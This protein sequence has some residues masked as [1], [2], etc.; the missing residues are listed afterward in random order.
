[1]AMELISFKLD[2][3]LARGRMEYKLDIISLLEPKCSHRVEAVGFSRW[4][5]LAGRNILTLSRPNR[6]TRKHLW[7]DLSLT[8]P[9]RS[10]PWMA[11]GDFNAILSSSEKKGG[12]VYGKRSSFFGEFVDMAKLQDL[13][14][15]G[16]HFIW[17]RG[18][19]FERL[20]HVLGNDTWV[21]SVPNC[22]VTHLPKMKSNHMP[23][24]LIL[25]QEIT[26]PRGRP[27]QSTCRSQGYCV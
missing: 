9:S 26:S 16:P 14:F 27:F 24:L 2:E 21:D 7:K 20:D 5:W 11:I 25:R 6:Q 13:G 4:I 3:M 12:Q 23:L 8:I 22:L 18:G 10:I 15:K 17:Y 19:L 1:M